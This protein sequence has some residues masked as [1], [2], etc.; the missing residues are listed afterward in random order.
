M[1]LAPPARPT[2]S[3]L[4]R[5]LKVVQTRRVVHFELQDLSTGRCHRFRSLT[6]LRRFLARA[7]AEEGAET[8]L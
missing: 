8:L 3:Y 7:S 6:S 1:T 2:A 4:L 5:V